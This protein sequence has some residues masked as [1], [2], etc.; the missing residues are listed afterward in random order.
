MGPFSAVPLRFG[1]LFGALGATETLPGQTPKRNCRCGA[2]EVGAR[3]L[4]M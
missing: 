1:N 4:R 2:A 3:A